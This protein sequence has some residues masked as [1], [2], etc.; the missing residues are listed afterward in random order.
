MRTSSLGSIP[1][2]AALG[3]A[4]LLASGIAAAQAYPARPIKLIVPF[5]PGGGTDI[6]ARE[7]ANK[8]ATSEGWT[9]VIDNKPGSGGNIGVDAAAKASP[10]GYTL[11][12]GQ[13]SNLA[14][15]PSLYTKLPYDPVKDLAAVGLVASAPLVVVVSSASPYKKLADVVAAAKAKPTALNYA[16]SGNG[17]VA[18]LA[19]EQFQK[20]AGIQL[21]HVPYKG[22]SQGMTD[23]VGGQI[24]LYVSSVPTLIAQIKSGQLRALA[25]TSLQRNRDLPDVPTMVEAGYKDFE[26][27]TWFGVAGPAAMPKDAIAKLNAAF[28]KALATPDVQKKLAAQGAEVLS[29][30]PEKFASLIRTDGVRWGAIV[31]ASGVRLD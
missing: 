10:D 3:L 14:I 1:R 22:A 15:N 2:S 11:V 6:I 5:P 20:I 25:V 27:V 18:H 17:T 8:V 29:G 4:L 21:T 24:Q 9:I 28:N 31:K 26:A 12:L 16:S 7:V 19:T 30:P 13:T 23:L